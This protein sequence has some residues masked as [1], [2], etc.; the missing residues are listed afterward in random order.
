MSHRNSAAL[1]TTIF[2]LDPDFVKA[3]HHFCAG[4]KHWDSEVPADELAVCPLCLEVMLSVQQ[5][6]YSKEELV[7]MLAALQAVAGDEQYHEQVAELFLVYP[8]WALP[9]CKN[10]NKNSTVQEVTLWGLVATQP[11]RF[12]RSLMLHVIRRV[13]DL[14]QQRLYLSQMAR[15]VEAANQLFQEEQQQ[16][17]QDSEGV[18][19]L[20]ELR[21]H[22]LMQPVHSLY[23]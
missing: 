22:P 2:E 19:R 3:Q 12:S 14:Y 10:N 16:E 18:K 23:A 8:A 11:P 1:T 21:Q 7:K 5:E 9:S 13:W 17:Q 20:A 4:C 6:S 15:G